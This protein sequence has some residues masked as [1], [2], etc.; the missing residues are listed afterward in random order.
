MPLSPD[1]SADL[2]MIENFGSSAPIVRRA[3]LDAVGGYDEATPPSEDFD[4]NFRIASR[5]PIA[6]ISRVLLHK[7]AHA[8][9]LSS[10]RPRLLR[11]E[12]L[13]RTRMLREARLRR[14]RRALREKLGVYYRSLAYYYTGRDNHLAVRYALTSMRVSRRPCPKHVA[15]I[16]ADLGGRDT[17][18]N[19]REC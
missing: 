5:Y 18:R 11:S 15:R 10:N 8:G 7:R 17:W 6:V 14:H 4:L 12:I 19:A 1:V 2:L 13:V 16:L 3:A 9:N